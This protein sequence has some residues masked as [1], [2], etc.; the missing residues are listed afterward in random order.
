VRVVWSEDS[1]ADLDNLL[2]YIAQYSSQGM[3]NVANAIEA[4][5]A[6]IGR[7]PNAGRFNP[8]SGCRERLAGRFP[9][10]LLYF[11]HDDYAEIIALFHTSRDPAEKRRP[12]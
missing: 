5:I 8:Q 9:I 2:G 1:L 7:F 3:A 12:S 6:Q 11:V 10:L 4:T